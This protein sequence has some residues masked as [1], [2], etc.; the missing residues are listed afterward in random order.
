MAPRAASNVRSRAHHGTAALLQHIQKRI[1]D[2]SW[3]VGHRLPPE[4]DLVEM[5][6]I[7][8]NTLRKALNNL[9][10]GGV[11]TR[12]V[13]RGTFIA[14]NVANSTISGSDSL[15]QRI[16]GASPADVM[17]LRLILEPPFV[18]VAATRATSRDLQQI[19]HC[20]RQSEAAK[21]VLEFEHWDGMLH[22]AILAS[23]HNHLLTDLYEVINGVRK[24]PEWETLKQRSLTPARHKQYK[25]QHRQIVKA[26]SMRDAQ[27]ASKKVQEHLL[28]VKSGMI[29]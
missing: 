28:E 6:G 29:G 26:L 27:T 12:H 16:H 5:F 13:G 10:H 11:I 15:I 18:A 14:T 9:A 1:G 19:S 20:L 24:Q 22:Q 17:E 2:G 3:P 4:R 25:D 23:T 8:R 21:T 7:A